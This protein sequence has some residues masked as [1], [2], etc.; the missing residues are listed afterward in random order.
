[1]GGATLRGKV[2][3]LIQYLDGYG[4]LGDLVRA[5]RADRPNLSF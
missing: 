1:V 3:N 4:Y 2:Q 5:V